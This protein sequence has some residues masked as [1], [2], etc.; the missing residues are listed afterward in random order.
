MPTST[1][2]LAKQLG[3]AFCANPSPNPNPSTNPNQGRLAEHEREHGHEAGA[4]GAESEPIEIFVDREPSVVHWLLRW[5]RSRVKMPA[6]QCPSSA[7]APPQG[8][9]GGSGRLETPRARDW[10]SGR[11]ATASGARASRL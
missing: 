11:P 5:F 8:A 2:L 9:P 7:P 6:W 4:G 1:V 3:S 10:P